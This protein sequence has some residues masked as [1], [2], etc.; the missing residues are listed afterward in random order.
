MVVK[1]W[2]F[3]DGRGNDVANSNNWLLQIFKGVSSDYTL[4]TTTE[5]MVILQ[6]FNFSIMSVIT[7][8]SDNLNKEKIYKLQILIKIFQILMMRL[9]SSFQTKVIWLATSQ[10][11][12]ISECFH[13]LWRW[14]KNIPLTLSDISIC[15]GLVSWVFS[16]H[17][18]LLN[19]ERCR[20]Y[21]SI[22]PCLFLFSPPPTQC[23]AVR[24]Q[25]PM[26][27]RI[28]DCWLISSWQLLDT[29]T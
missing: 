17:N 12:S 29:E 15:L 27:C 19:V 1:F 18:S 25:H 28:S 10:P 20:F 26:T 2:T 23:R 14:N 24:P 21:L 5:T 11:F 8:V 7:F 13:Y 4:G 16:D 3:C 6:K 22:Q 9:M